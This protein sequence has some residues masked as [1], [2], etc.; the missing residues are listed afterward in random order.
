MSLKHQENVVCPFCGC[1]CD[2]LAVTVEGERITALENACGLARQR[3]AAFP[4]VALPGGLIAGQPAEVGAAISAAAEV[5]LASRNPLVYGLLGVTTE[6]Q[7]AAVAVADLL[8]ATVDSAA[9]DAQRAGAQALARGYAHFATLG[10][11]RN[12]ADLVVYW[13][14]DPNETHPRHVER[15]TAPSDRRRERTLIVIGSAAALGADVVVAGVPGRDFELIAAL[16]GVLRG[17]PTAPA[18]AEAAGVPLETLTNLA[19]RLKGCRYG[20][21]YYGPQLGTGRDGPHAVAA[22]YALV[23]DLNAHSRVFAQGMGGHANATGAD[24]VL[25]W[26][27]GYAQSVTYGRGY[28]HANGNEF[29]AAELLAQGEVDAALVVGAEPTAELPPAAVERLRQM[30]SVVIG[31]DAAS[32]AWATVAIPTA[33]VG[34][35]AGGT[36]YRMDE[37]ALTARAILPAPYPATETVL[38]DLLGRLRGGRGG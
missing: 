3:Y 22:L 10:E 21:I 25:A 8:R 9:T 30:P 7:R 36:L 28:P 17:L 15:Y 31:P 20:A 14:A 5:L 11:V 37:V 26:Q 4:R 33:V 18:L 19:D 34:L 27:S 13:G 35:E 23:T 29:S 2:D 12:L 32:A 1:L 6:A 16:R 24:N 38:H